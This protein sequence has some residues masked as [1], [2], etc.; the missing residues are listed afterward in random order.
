MNSST[1]RDLALLIARVGLGVVFV[2]H[3]WQKFFTTG[4]DNV[5]TGFRGMDIP[6]P[7]ASAI[8]A[9]AVE[10]GGGIALIA[11]VLTSIAGL[12]LFANMLGAFAFVHIENGVFVSGGGY[13]LVV[14]LGVGAL[15]I[16]VT[17]AGKFSI[18]ASFGKAVRV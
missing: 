8:F 10:L 17:G 15:L 13:E 9:A 4:L 11:G 16:A 7:R 2:A 18:D 6:A 3:G 14:A 5:T 12:L 1:Q